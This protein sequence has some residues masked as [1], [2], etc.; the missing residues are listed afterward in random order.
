MLSPALNKLVVNKSFLLFLFVASCFLV[1]FIEI[2]AG[3]SFRRN[4]QN[5]VINF[6]TLLRLKFLQ[7]VSI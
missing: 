3:K 6:P 4:K 1:T 2:Q 7:N 5:N